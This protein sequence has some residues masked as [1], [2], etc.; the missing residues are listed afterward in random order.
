[1]KQAHRKQ[2]HD[3]RGERKALLHEP[4]QATGDRAEQ[5]REENDDVESSEA[6]HVLSV[7]G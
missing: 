6:S 4:P 2:R 7:N 3:Q 1:M 5:Q